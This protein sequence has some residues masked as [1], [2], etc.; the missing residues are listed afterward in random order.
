MKTL[1]CLGFYSC[2]ILNLHV[3][4]QPLYDL[5]KDSTPFHWTHEH[6]KIFQSI[7][8]RISEDTIL[9]VPST[10][11]FFHIHVDSMKV[12]LG[13]ILIQQFPNGKRIISLNLWI[14]DKV[15]Q[16]MSTLHLELCGIISDL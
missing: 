5:I 4:S 11:Y 7:N 6:E 1:E 12:G 2:Y 14:F 10:D 15:E 9:A 13:C 8:D 16:K 3:D